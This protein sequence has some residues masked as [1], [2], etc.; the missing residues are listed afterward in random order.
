MSTLLLVDADPLSLRVLDVSLRQAGFEVVTARDSEDALSKVRAAAPDLLVTDTRLRDS[1]GFALVKTLRERP[2]AAELPVI[3]LSRAEAEDERARATE[4]GVEDILSK[5]VFV[6]EL[7][8]RVQLLLARRVQRAAAGG[9]MAGTTS[10]LA[11]VDLLQSLEASHTTGVVHLEQLQDERETARIYLRDGNV[12]D[13]ELDRLRGAEVVVRA[14]GWALASFRVEPGP[15]D[16]DDLLE[17][18]THALLMRALDRIDGRTPPPPAASEPALPRQ[19]EAQV[20]PEPAPEPESVVQTQTEAE[21]AAPK[22]ETRPG[23]RSRERSLPST[24]PWTRE[25]EPSDPPAPEVELHAAGVPGAR[26]RTIRRVALVAAAAGAALLLVIGLTSVQ[27]RHAREADAARAALPTS[28]A[29][30]A[31]GG[32]SQALPGSSP[33]DAV[34]A[35]AA[36]AADPTAAASATP[37][38]VSPTAP[39]GVASSAPDAPAAPAVD[40]RET[41]LHVNT[42]LHARSALV[43]D[44]D[45]ALLNGDTAK[46]ISLAQQAVASNPA[47]AEGWL[48]LAAARKAAGDASGARDAYTR[49]IAQGHT[50]GVMSCRALAGATR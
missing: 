21:A 26:T 47:D 50:V 27:A 41:A 2:G 34:I 3:F 32:P 4:L 29:A 15:V 23:A 14:L 6:R 25:S 38:P 45:R 8:A 30:A 33:L 46:A 39:E 42:Q 9:P 7:L 18:T 11:L 12:V 35:A 19:V 44:A 31:A 49:C 28:P 1:D 40:P 48:T 43:R 5:P 16:N 37:D 22:L 17:C 36:T 10:E 20:E 24:A 13:A